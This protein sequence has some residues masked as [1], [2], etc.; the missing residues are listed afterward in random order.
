VT[1]QFGLKTHMAKNY[2]PKTADLNRR[3]NIRGPMLERSYDE[4]VIFSHDK[5]IITNFQS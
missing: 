1:V 4:F 5:V 2:T 3:Y